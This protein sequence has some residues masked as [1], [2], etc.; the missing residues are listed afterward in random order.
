[1]QFAVSEP[2]TAFKYVNLL[3]A[4]RAGLDYLLFRRGILADSVV[5]TGGFFRTD[6]NMT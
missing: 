6:S 5:P 2:I 1:M 3:G 4:T